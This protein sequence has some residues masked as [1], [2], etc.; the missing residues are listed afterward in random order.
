M[1]WIFKFGGITS[2]VNNLIY[3]NK[4]TR[5]VVQ[6]LVLS[7]TALLMLN[8]KT[9]MHLQ[10]HALNTITV[11]MYLNLFW[12]HRSLLQLLPVSCLCSR[13][14][15]HSAVPWAIQ[16]VLFRIF[17]TSVIYIYFS[18]HTPRGYMPGIVVLTCKGQT[19]SPYTIYNIT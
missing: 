14:W 8:P 2:E 17:F 19:Q 11:Y 15:H 1:W 12:L 16:L 10:V 5:I 4:Q 6:L 18:S 7:H 3:K 13:N 9:W